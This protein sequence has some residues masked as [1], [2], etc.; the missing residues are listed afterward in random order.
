MVEL[1][2]KCPD[3]YDERVSLMCD[4]SL[5]VCDIQQ[6][7]KQIR[8]LNIWACQFFCFPRRRNKNI[9]CRPILDEH[10]PNLNQGFNHVMDLARQI[11]IPHELNLW[12]MC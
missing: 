9:T 5:S 2:P 7:S 11:W 8:R 6:A 3:N 12:T 1:A 4:I 10:G